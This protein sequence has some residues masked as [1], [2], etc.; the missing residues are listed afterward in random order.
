MLGSSKPVVFDP[1]GG[2]RKRRGVPRWLVLLLVGIAAGAGGVI[3]VQERYLPPRLSASASTQLRESYEQADAER[4][5][6]RKEI[7]DATRRMDEAIAAQKSHAGELAS[8]KSTIEALREDLMVVVDGL[9]PDPRGGSV[10]VRAWR[11]SMKGGALAYDLV[12]WRERA[13]ERPMSAVVQLDVS[14]ESARGTETT[15]RSKP[16]TVSV[17][18][19]EAVRGS[20]ALPEGFRPRQATVRVLD[21]S[22]G[23][24]LGM[25]VMYVK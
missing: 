9:P 11:F 25:R 12:L 19:F 8:A 24:S 2:R 14:G 21:R 22:E 16:V 15:V 6:L 20:L 1:Y 3:Y 18:R 10:E 23:R 13:G 5:R 7:G 4:I 17:G